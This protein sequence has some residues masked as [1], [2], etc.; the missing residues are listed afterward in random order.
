MISSKASAQFPN[1]PLHHQTMRFS[2]LQPEHDP[3]K[4]LRWIGIMILNLSGLP[5]VLAALLFIGAEDSRVGV[6]FFE[7][8]LGASIL[9]AV[10]FLL[11]GAGLITMLAS[12]RPVVAYNWITSLRR[13]TEGKS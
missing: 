11:V 1:L 9:G 3:Q 7:H 10:G 4:S 5:I 6:S 13:L 8:H 12:R 2:V